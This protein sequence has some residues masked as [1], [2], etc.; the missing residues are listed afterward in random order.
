MYL[1]VRGID[2]ASF[3]DFDIQ[4]WNCFDS[5]LIFVFH[6]LL[7]QEENIRLKSSLKEISGNQGHFQAREQELMTKIK[8]KVNIN[9]YVCSLNW[10]ITCN[11]CS[12]II[13][14]I[15]DHLTKRI[16]SPFYGEKINQ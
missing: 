13:F 12:K 3:Y 2:F 10:S 5:V 9:M 15:V 1:Y 14:Y 11:F 8:L 7:W 16:Y 6:F 4:F